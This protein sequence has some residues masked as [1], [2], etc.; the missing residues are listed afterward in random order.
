LAVRRAALGA[1]RLILENRLR[2]S[3][4]AAFAQALGGYGDQLPDVD[5]NTLSSDLL[6]FFAERLKVHLRDAGVRHD[7]ISAVFA[8]GGDDDLVRLLARVEALRAFLGTEDGANLLTALRRASNIVRIEEKR[9]RR[10]Y[11]GEPDRHR[12]HA[13]EEQE[14]FF[15]LM[16][17][18]DDIVGAL[19]REA[20]GEAMTA[21]ARMRQ[22][23]DAFFDRVTVNANEPEVREN[24]LYLLNQIRSAL[25]AVAD[26]SL[27]E[28]TVQSAEGKRRVA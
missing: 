10:S 23:V 27:I 17:V 19:E 20:F 12:L 6:A 24:R 28:D 1:I 3:L 8:A 11:A 26:F 2:L 16:S 18:S 21:L 15:R 4:R 7:L 22:P 5:A 25:S 14:L 9:D 13:P